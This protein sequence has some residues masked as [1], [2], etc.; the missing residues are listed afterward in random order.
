MEVHGAVPDGAPLCGE[1]LM[2]PS[3]IRPL[4]ADD[5]RAAYWVQYGGWSTLGDGRHLRLVVIDAFGEWEERPATAP[6]DPDAPTLN[7]M[8]VKHLKAN[9]VMA[10]A[11]AALEKHK[12]ESRRNP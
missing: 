10:R 12:R 8:I 9:G 2:S 4:G 1:L 3:D 5:G 11:E 7:E 6:F